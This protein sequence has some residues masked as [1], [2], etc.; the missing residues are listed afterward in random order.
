MRWTPDLSREVRLLSSNE[1]LLDIKDLVVHYETEDAVIEAVN[2]VSFEVKRG[3]ILGIVGETGAGK[4]TIGLSIMGLL[5]KPPA[6]VIQ[7]SIKFNGR[8][9]L[10][11]EEHTSELQSRPQLVCRLLL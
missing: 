10:R 4:T 11:S 6:N 9:L 3:E 1:K 8:E 5:P 7:G 2:N